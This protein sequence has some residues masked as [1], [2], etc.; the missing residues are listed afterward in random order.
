MNGRSFG[1][2]TLAEETGPD[3]TFELSF[4][5]TGQDTKKTDDTAQPDLDV[6][7][8]G[9]LQIQDRTTLGL[10]TN[11]ATAG[12]DPLVD[13]SDEKSVATSLT[14]T[15]PDQYVMASSAGIGAGNRVHAKLTDQYG[16]SV[17]RN[18]IIRSAAEPEEHR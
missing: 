14:L 15:M 1:Y 16:S 4:R 7:D 10:L 17:G 6:L 8:S 9:T 3:G 13:W 11:D 5:H 12:Q 2:R 18:E